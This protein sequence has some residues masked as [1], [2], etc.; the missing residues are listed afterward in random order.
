MYGYNV[1]LCFSIKFHS[2]GM[3][4]VYLSDERKLLIVVVPL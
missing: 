2:Y 3:T 4:E 1:H